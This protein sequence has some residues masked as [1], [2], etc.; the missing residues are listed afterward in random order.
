MKK[1]CGSF[2]SMRAVDANLQYKFPWPKPL[3]APWF[4]IDENYPKAE[5]R[6][7]VCVYSYI[8]PLNVAAHLSYPTTKP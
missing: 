5:T 4:S 3:N 2:W 1:M 8:F 6:Q 7:C